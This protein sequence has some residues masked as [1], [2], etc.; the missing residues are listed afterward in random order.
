METIF[1]VKSRYWTYVLFGECF[2]TIHG[3]VSGTGDHTELL[4]DLHDLAAQSLDLQL[5][6]WFRIWFL[7]F[8]YFIDEI[9]QLLQ[10]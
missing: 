7:F 10:K 9:M 3:R 8:I 6:G 4:I 5:V 1:I 2:I